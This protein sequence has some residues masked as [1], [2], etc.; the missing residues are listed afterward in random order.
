MARFSRSRPD[1]YNNEDE[2]KVFRFLSNLPNDWLVVWGYRYQDSH[3]ESR[4]GDFLVLGPQGGLMVVEVKGRKTLLVDAEGHWI[5]PNHDNP[6]FQLD[7]QWDAIKKALNNDRDGRVS[8]T[9]IR[10][11]SVPNISRAK[12][13][14]L[15]HAAESGALILASEDLADFVAAWNRAF[16]D[17]RFRKYYPNPDSRQLFLDSP[18]GLRFTTHPDKVIGD[19]LDAEI[20]RF[21]RAQFSVLNHLPTY[22]RFS[23]TGAAGT[24]KTWLLLALALRWASR[25]EEDT[26]SVLLLCY[27]KAL[28]LTLESLIKRLVGKSRS[29]RN[30]AQRICVRSWESI[31]EDCLRA[32]GESFNPPKDPKGRNRYFS[33]DIPAALAL[34]YQEGRIVPAYDSLVVDEAQDHDTNSGGLA[35]GWWTIYRA[36]L[37]NPG[38]APIAVAYDSAQRPIFLGTKHFSEA[39]LLDWIG[40]DAVRLQCPLMLRYSPSIAHYLAPLAQKIGVPFGLPQPLENSA[41]DGPA[42]TERTTHSAEVVAAV[43]EVAVQWLKAGVVIPAEILVITAAENWHTQLGD[44]LADCELV[45]VE[46]RSHNNISHVTAGRCKG[47]EARAVIVVGFYPFDR[48]PEGYRH[49]FFLAASRARQLLA[50]INV[51]P[52]PAQSQGPADAPIPAPT[53]DAPHAH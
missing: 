3:G 39:K 5:G 20:D 41:I 30:A 4:E 49:S 16:G 13:G 50:I 15:P 51:E 46:E 43:N 25:L 8:I 38:Q 33:E 2:G 23:I 45:P 22:H 52:P 24:G 35:H 40:A 42:V 18:W 34:A 14:T 1:E 32:I 11:L 29:E 19:F 28:Q 9:V 44:R 27:N 6:F 10:A 37:K 12:A 47:L 26:G 7:A 36:L 48:L 21:T 17:D 53:P 31:V